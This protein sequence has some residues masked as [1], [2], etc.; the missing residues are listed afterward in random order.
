MLD[1]RFHEPQRVMEVQAHHA[2][3]LNLDIDVDLGC[4]KAAV[5]AGV[6]NIRVRHIVFA[7]AKNVHNYL[8]GRSVL[9]GTEQAIAGIAESGH[10]VP[11]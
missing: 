3:S 11:E 1:E 9:D 6:E 10:D 5:Y 7:K 2:P 4:C 8:S